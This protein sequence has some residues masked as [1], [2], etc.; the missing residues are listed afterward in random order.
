MRSRLQHEVARLRAIQKVNRSVRDAEVASIVDQQQALETY[1][2]G[3]RLRLDAIRLI[4]RGG[5][6]R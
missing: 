5:S 4:H 1:M 3:A 6:P 2:D